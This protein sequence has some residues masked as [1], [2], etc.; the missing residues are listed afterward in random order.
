M[1]DTGI[2][3]FNPIYES[4]IYFDFGVS[5]NQ[6]GFAFELILSLKIVNFVLGK[7]KNKSFRMAK[8]THG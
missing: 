5:P 2:A 7:M 3:I 1:Y 6:I 4:D 8:T